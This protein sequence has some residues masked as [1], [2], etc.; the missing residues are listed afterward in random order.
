MGETGR[1]IGHD[2][3]MTGNK[4]VVCVVTMKALVESLQS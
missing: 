2:I 1:I 4:E 3:E